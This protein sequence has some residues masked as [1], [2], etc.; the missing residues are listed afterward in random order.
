MLFF[1]LF[2]V[3]SLGRGGGLYLEGRIQGG[4][5]FRNFTVSEFLLFF[6]PWGQIIYF[7]LRK[8]PGENKLKYG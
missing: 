2:C 5:Y 3:T 1:S 4:A 6:G 8:K 7:V